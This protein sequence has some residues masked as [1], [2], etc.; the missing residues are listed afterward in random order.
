MCSIYS[1]LLAAFLALA[2][3]TCLE[4]TDA[5]AP[6]LTF[7]S[8]TV[9]SHAV[10]PMPFVRAATMLQ[11]EAEEAAETGETVAENAE[12]ETEEEPEEE[13]EDPEVTALKDEIEE[14]EKTLKDKKSQIMYLKDSTETYSKGGYA[15]KVAEMENMRRARNCMASSNRETSIATVLRNFLPVKDK[16]DLLR[17]QYAENEFG[18]QYVDLAGSFNTALAE[19]GV[20]DYTAAS[21]ETADRTRVLVV[22]E[23]NSAEYPKDTVIRPLKLGLELKGNV[24][25]LAECVGS[26][27]EEGEGEEEESSEEGAEE[28]EE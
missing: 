22:E 28:S 25:R 5:F 21:G 13:P 12:E 10:L 11:A 9:S 4:S 6:S 15:R 8:R 26:L 24:V 17:Q 2:A 18:K 16:L 27:G 3:T 1:S 14:L 20:T 23:E 19:M 7:S